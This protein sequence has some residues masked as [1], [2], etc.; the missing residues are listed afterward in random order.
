MK[1]TK[2]R[3]KQIIKE[4]LGNMLNERSEERTFPG[5][6]NQDDVLRY[7]KKLAWTTLAPEGQDNLKILT[8]EKLLGDPS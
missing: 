5:M 8:K 4:E 1:I 7:A 2:S 6:P 3:L